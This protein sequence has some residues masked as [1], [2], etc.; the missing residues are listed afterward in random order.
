[1]RSEAE[2]AKMP[3]TAIVASIVAGYLVNETLFLLHRTPEQP[4]AGLL[5]SQKL[6]Y[7][8]KPY[9]LDIYTLPANP[10]CLAHEVWEPILTLP[11]SPQT[12]TTQDL[13]TL[14][15]AQDG[16]LELDFDLLTEVICVECGAKEEI[17]RPLEKCPA[18]LSLCPACGKSTRQPETI[19][20][21]DS[22]SEF[23]AL[24]LARLGVPEYG[25]LRIKSATGEQFVQLS[26]VY[27]AALSARVK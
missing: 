26:G 13:L 15:E 6:I 27:T 11:Q 1:L 21:L 20:W 19:T 16:T 10:H 12:L 5:P 25:V 7:L 14:L 3:T 24:P 4:K 22:A 9:R 8:L 18:S 2:E 23:A 17:F